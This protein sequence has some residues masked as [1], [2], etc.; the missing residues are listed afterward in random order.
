MASNAAIL[1][2]HDRVFTLA[3]RTHVLLDGAVTV[4]KAYD[5]SIDEY[6]DIDL[7]DRSAVDW[8]SFEAGFRIAQRL[9]PAFVTPILDIFQPDDMP[10]FEAILTQHQGDHYGWTRLSSEKVDEDDA[11]MILHGLIDAISYLHTQKVLLPD[12]SLEHIAIS[13]TNE[14]RLTG[15]ST[16]QAYGQD[17][18][19]PAVKDELYRIG[20]CVQSLTPGARSPEFQELIRRLISENEDERWS[21][22]E[23]LDHQLLKRGF[24]DSVIDQAAWFRSFSDIL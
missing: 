1:R 9:S 4:Y 7:I 14:V 5:P 20:L 2:Q 21:L 11:I 8:P 3:E 19:A 6:Y 24:F 23:L 13:Q 15:F 17:T 22:Q 18:G 16:A 12:F 10:G